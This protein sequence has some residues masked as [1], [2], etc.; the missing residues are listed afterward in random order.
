M[1]HGFFRRGVGEWGRCSA[2]VSSIAWIY[3]NLVAGSCNASTSPS[4]H[5]RCKFLLI[6]A[7]DD[8]KSKRVLEQLSFGTA[9]FTTTLRKHQPL[10]WYPLRRRKSSARQV[11][12]H[13]SYYAEKEEESLLWVLG[14]LCPV[15]SENAAS[16]TNQPRHW[17]Q[18]FP[19]AS[20]KEKS[21]LSIPSH[22][23]KKR[24]SVSENRRE[25]IIKY[26]TLV[27]ILLQEKDRSKAKFWKLRYI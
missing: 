15:S 1:G 23:D 16:F 25:G 13:G 24:T 2:G 8:K 21:Y 12:H 5:P 19:H 10:L 18:S 17:F 6:C 7:C 20:A 11:A 22:R 9:N 14:I 26:L 27:L 4:P 3:N